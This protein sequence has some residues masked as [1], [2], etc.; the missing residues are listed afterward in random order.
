MTTPRGRVYDLFVLNVALQL[1]DAVATYQGL[2]FGFQEAN[3]LLRNAFESFGVLPALLE[4]KAVACGLLF[5]MNCHP[6][7]Q[8][9]AAGLTAVAG[10]Y[11]T[12]SLCPWL[13]KFA[14]LF[15]QSI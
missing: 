8:F 7:H 13:G 1:F 4:F 2:Q 3:P 11:S 6:A 15:V 14:I 12:F 10:V 5:L 9:V